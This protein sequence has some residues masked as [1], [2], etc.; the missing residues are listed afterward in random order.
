M[1]AAGELCRE[2]HLGEV[3]LLVVGGWWSTN[4]GE[5]R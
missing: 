1:L 4:C 2:E 3:L 5:Q